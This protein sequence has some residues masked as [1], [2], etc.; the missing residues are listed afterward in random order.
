MRNRTFPNSVA[1]ATILGCS[2]IAA[3]PAGAQLKVELDNST[4]RDFPT[5]FY[6]ANG[7]ERNTVPW[8]DGTPN[9]NAGQPCTTPAPGSGSQFN[10]ALQQLQYGI[11]RFPTGTGSDWWNYRT[12]D[13]LPM[14]T[15]YSPA[16][17]FGP[18]CFPSPVSELAGEAEAASNP[19]NPGL[20]A[21]DYVVNTITDPHC[22]SGCTYGSPNESY[23]LKALQALT[24]ALGSQNPPLALTH[25]ELG[26]ETSGGGPKATVYPNAT[27]Y[28]N[29]MAAWIM[30]IKNTYPS[31]RI[32]IVGDK[33]IAF[34]D[35][36]ACKN[37]R[38]T[39]WDS[40]LMQALTG[41]FYT[42]DNRPDAVI[43]HI[44]RRSDLA[45]NVLVTDA[46][47]ETMFTEPYSAWD[48]LT[49]TLFPA[50][51]VAGVYTPKIWFTEYNLH[52]TNTPPLASGTWASG[53]YTAMFSLLFATNTRVELAIHHE[54]QARAATFP[55]IFASTGAFKSLPFSGTPGEIPT[56]LYGYSAQ[57]ITT[58]A[59]DRA[60]LGQTRA[61]TLSFNNAPTL[62]GTHP[63]LL[64]EYYCGSQNGDC[65]KSAG[66][67]I[68]LNLD[69]I[70]HKLDL[71]GIMSS[72]TYYQ[73]FGDA[74][75]YVDGAITNNNTHFEAWK[76]SQDNTGAWSKT[77]D[78]LIVD[79]GSLSS[80]SSFNV[81]PFS[82]T[83]I[84]VA[85]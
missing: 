6:G 63:V 31:V 55:D 47:A 48:K 19:D 65:Q 61:E 58:R 16:P 12:G 32:G 78:D 57:G 29:T 23:Q 41:P 1:L 81:H 53:L 50:L 10:A 68:I 26:N 51:R 7:A 22:T 35:Y 82:I 79:H 69:N 13:L 2:L 85:N 46:N 28:A 84:I 42:A 77:E 73:T 37:A 18:S 62:D 15:G 43:I 24:N 39:N 70:S 3:K 80:P 49:G 71:T 72:G 40:A 21:V 75:A 45:A 74:G 20:A 14:S 33:C 67:I 11:L 52:D 9:P 66:Q 36:D 34:S 54:V 30:D 25:V 64:G 60:S 17:K 5:N 76:E 56:S 38:E 59:I 4:F 8:E 27:A 83:R 44:Y